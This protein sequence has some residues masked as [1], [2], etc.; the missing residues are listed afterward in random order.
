MGDLSVW[1]FFPLGIE[2]RES[3]ME[4]GVN[5]IGWAFVWLALSAGQ[6]LAQPA[7]ENTR[8][9]RSPNGRLTGEVG[10]CEGDLVYDLSCEGRAILN[11]S[12]L[13]LDCD[14]P[15]EGGWE[16]VEATVPAQRADWSPVY[17]ER[18]R[19]PDQSRDVVIQLRERGPLAR[20]VQVEFRV[21]NEGLAF[22]WVLPKQAG[23]ERW[24]IK[25]ERSE[26]RF[27]AGS[28]AWPIYST[29]QTFS[30]QP[31]PLDQHPT[32]I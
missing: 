10:S 28:V 15:F 20:R 6:A 30:P 25:R 29:E 11:R 16:L 17:G 31:V 7:T 24:R 19:Y 32:P 12:K 27:A 22:R 13:Q 4:C 26:F 23:V 3:L 9:L 8:S 5:R 2:R 18:C 21:Y 14:L 1:C